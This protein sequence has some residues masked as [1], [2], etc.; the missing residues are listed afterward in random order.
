M[1]ANRLKNDVAKFG[2]VWIIPGEK[3]GRY[4]ACNALYVEADSKYLIDPGANRERLDQLGRESGVDTV[5]LSHYHEDHIAHLDLFESKDLWISEPDAPALE[6]MALFLDAYGMDDPKIRRH[7]TDLMAQVFHYRPRRAKRLFKGAETLDLGGVTVEVI[8]TPG[9]TLGHVSFFFREPALLFLGDYDLTA[10]GPWYGDRESDIDA[11]IASVQTLRKIEA[12]VWVVSHE[13]G[14]Y[15]ENPGVL[16]DRYLQVIEDREAQLLALL[17]KPRTREE[18]IEA[19]IIYRK[20]KEPAAF[21]DFSE[22]ALM[23][24]HIKRLARQGRVIENGNAYQLA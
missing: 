7:W 4:P 15:T 13:P 5:W 16:W 21:F 19:R 23:S 18:I 10:F 11:T 17:E 6:D 8:P 14:V 22:W 20:K 1:I 12:K 2:P 9:H 24:K 3:S